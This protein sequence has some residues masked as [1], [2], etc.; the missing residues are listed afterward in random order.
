MEPDMSTSLQQAIDEL[1]KAFPPRR[2]DPERAF[3]D[4]GTTYLSGDEFKAG[5]RGKSWDALDAEFLEFHHD[6]TVFL[7]PESFGEYLPAYLMI[8]L[9][10]RPEARNLPAFLRGLLTRS[11]DPAWFDARVERLTEEQKRAVA[12]ALEA[13]EAA[14][15]SEYDKQDWAGVLDGYWRDLIDRSSWQCSVRKKDI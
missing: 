4:G 1:R 13:L 10:R 8:L 5:V 11:S 6:A 12:R 2:L 15:E 9:E 14:A 3:G 7:P